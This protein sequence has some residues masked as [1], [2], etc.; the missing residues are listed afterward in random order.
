M[1]EHLQGPDALRPARRRRTARSRDG[2]LLKVV[3]MRDQ[4]FLMSH[5]EPDE[6]G[7]LSPHNLPAPLT[8]LIGREQEV[9]AVRALLARHE[10]RLLTLT[11]PGG[12]GKTR[13][14]LQVAYQ[15]LTAFPD[16]VFLVSL[17]PM[18]D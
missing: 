8:P 3:A 7:H 17:A 14:A 16:G 9:G 13:L 10:V 15:L 11:G 18:S 4:L 1:P 2:A 12:V 6:S 5:P